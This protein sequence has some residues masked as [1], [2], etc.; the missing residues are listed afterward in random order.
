MKPFVPTIGYRWWCFRSSEALTFVFL[1]D[2][3]SIALKLMADFN[4]FCSNKDGLLE[5][6]WQSNQRTTEKVTDDQA[7]SEAIRWFKSIYLNFCAYGCFLTEIL[8]SRAI[9][10]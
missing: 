1:I 5:K 6:F 3:S 8:P 9:S 2:D 4:N 10:C 7:E